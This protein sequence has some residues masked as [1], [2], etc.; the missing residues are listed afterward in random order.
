M[1]PF[2]PTCLVALLCIGA[3]ETRASCGASF[4]AVNLSPARAADTDNRFDMRF[5][6]INQDQ[7]RVGRRKADVGEVRGHH[8]EVRTI[9]RNLVASFDFPL[10]ADWALSVQL[11]FVSRVHRHIHHHH[12]AQLL[13]AWDIDTIGDA[14]VLG[15]RRLAGPNNTGWTLTAGVKL[16]TG[17]FDESN[18]ADQAAERSLQP[19]SGTTDAVVGARYD[20][21]TTWG[22]VALRGFASVQLQT[23]LRERDQYRPGAQYSVD[24]GADYAFTPTWK[25]LLQINGQIKQR[26][27]G[28]D[29][30]PGTTGGSFAWLSAGIAYAVGPRQEIYG[31]VQLPLYQRVNGIQLTA[32]YALIVGFNT[33]L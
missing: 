20:V 24:V 19:G 9:N 33:R 25:G 22:G 1:R 13:E 8:D 32:D 17:S 23:P 26:D 18:A 6:Y 28:A 31:L 5:E 10:S 27:R 7:P 21:A 29:A 4:C 14:R 3:A 30:E 15:R 12:G 11:P 2:V 16:A